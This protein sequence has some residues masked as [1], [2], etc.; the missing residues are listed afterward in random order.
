[1]RFYPPNPGPRPFHS[2]IGPFPS[3]RRSFHQYSSLIYQDP[4]YFS[5]GLTQMPPQGAPLP[6][7]RPGILGSFLQGLTQGPPLGF[8]PSPQTPGMPGNT[9]QVPSQ[10]EVASSLQTDLLENTDQLPTQAGA[11]D[12][13]QTPGMWENIN[14]MLTYAEELSRGIETFRKIGSVFTKS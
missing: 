1:M 12:P 11:G 10:E 5:H 4:R 13:P 6:P 9:N 14:Q 7:Q 8:V 2:F 3:N